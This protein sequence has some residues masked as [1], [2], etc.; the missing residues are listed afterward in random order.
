MLVR[1]TLTHKSTQLIQQLQI[2]MIKKLQ[3]MQQLI[4]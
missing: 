2:S 4:H 3:L 1:K